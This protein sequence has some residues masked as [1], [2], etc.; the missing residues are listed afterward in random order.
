[1]RKQLTLILLGICCVATST[2]SIAA[3]AKIVNGSLPNSV[4]AQAQRG[5]VSATTTQDDVPWGLDI[6]DGVD[7]GV[8][9]YP[10]GATGEGVDVY[11]IDTGVY[12][13]HWQFEGR[14]IAG[15][16]LSSPGSDCAQTM[17]DGHGTHVAGTVGSKLFGVAKKVRIIDV[18]VL[19]NCGNGS[20]VAVEK[21]IKWVIRHHKSNRVAIAN[22]SLGVS[23]EPGDNSTEKLEGL[24]G[25]LLNDGV[26]AVVAAGNGDENDKAVDSCGTSPARAPEALTVSA[27]QEDLTRAGFANYGSCVDL[28]APGVKVLS[29]WNKSD[30]TVC[31]DSLRCLDT[32]TSMAVPHVAGIAALVAQKSPGACAQQVAEAVVAAAVK[33][34]NDPLTPKVNLA[35]LNLD[36]LPAPSAPGQANRVISTPGNT[37]MTVSWDAPCNGRRPITGSTIT[38]RS[39]GSNI[40]TV[41]IK[42]PSTSK[43][44]AGLV[45]GHEYSFS[46]SSKNDLG[47]GAVSGF[48]SSL[49]PFAFR[50]GM[51]KALSSFAS[52]GNG[53]KYRVETSTSTVCKIVAGSPS[54]LQALKQGTCTLV[55]RPPDADYTIKRD[56]KV[57]PRL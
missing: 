46:V 39:N 24:I 34:I 7:D 42:G 10:D 23:L 9:T 33:P 32:G 16:D 52:A 21:A 57:W 1:M 40:K 26:V 4:T 19:D 44:V 55:I 31:P 45:N 6:I 12:L 11:V 54:K 17:K 20:T 35:Q 41:K 49:K 50:V 22:M 27:L 18:R 36:V 2:V 15:I 38:V 5:T 3:S 43:V 47:P 29:T 13:K 56:I 28:F 14:A 8:Y 30:L 48:S 25:N 53:S 51:K 37:N